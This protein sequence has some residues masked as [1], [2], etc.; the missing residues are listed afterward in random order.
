[1][2]R[3]LIPAL[4]QLSLKSSMG[5]RPVL[6]AKMRW[7]GFRGSPHRQSCCLCLRRQALALSLSRQPRDVGWILRW[8]TGLSASEW[9]LGW[10][11]R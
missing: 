6:H 8:S 5:C 1:M 2:V 3:F 11:L 10:F 4:W 7:S 9:V